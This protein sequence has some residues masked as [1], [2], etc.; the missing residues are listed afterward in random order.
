MQSHRFDVHQHITDQIVAAIER[1][2]GEF[3]LPWHRSAA[4][5]MRPVNVASKA[6]YRGVNV[7]SLWASADANGYESG[8]WGTFRQWAA[9]GACVK[10]GERASHVVFYREITR[11][12]NDDP[13]EAPET[14]LLARASPVFAAEQVDGYAPPAAV[15]CNSIMKRNVE[16]DAFI[17]ATGASIMHGGWRAYYHPVTDSIHLP[18][19]ES[20]CGTATS[21][22][23]EAYYATVL[24]ELTHWTGCERR[25]NRQL[26]KRFGDGAYA[27]EELVAELGAAFLCGDLGVTDGPRLDHAQYL[28]SWLRILKTDKRA[29]FTAASKASQ[30][31]EFLGGL[32]AT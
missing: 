16:V 17:A 11:G 22:A 29:I 10:K 15:P 4:N 19:R 3:R 6:A 25:C 32:H 20:F 26:G 12:S 5:A 13:D 7:L 21:S 8:V 31:V 27:M 24:H 9:A 18:P 1:G 30:A 28:D 14:C 2:A 23:V